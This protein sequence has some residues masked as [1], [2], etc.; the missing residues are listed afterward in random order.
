MKKS[1]LVFTVLI[2]IHSTIWAGGTVGNGGDTYAIQFVD[3]ARKAHDELKK[4]GSSPIQL[5]LFINTI[6]TAVIESTDQQLYLNGAI[7]DAIN[8][9][10]ESKIIFNRKAW[11]NA[12]NERTRLLFVLHEYLGLMG[13]DDSRYN[14][15]SETLKSIAQESLIC[16]SVLENN[17]NQSEISG[18]IV[19]E[20][21]GRHQ[22][23]W[24]DGI[25]NYGISL[26][27]TSDPVFFVLAVSEVN[28]DVSSQRFTT[29]LPMSKPE[30]TF[31]FSVETNR[32]ING[33]PVKFIDVDCR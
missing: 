18:K 9:P 33:Y 20:L 23:S 29:Y 1:L 8:Y 26:N 4:K 13:V 17:Q 2:S 7:K 14:V 6:N 16:R 5:E 15:S 3:M 28:S 12:P 11:Q 19:L 31:S 10:A 25:R 21:T 32:K 22:A 24:S 30:V 27:A